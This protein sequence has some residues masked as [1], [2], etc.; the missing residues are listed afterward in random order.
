MKIRKNTEIENAL[1]AR[2]LEK[3]KPSVISTDI[4]MHA[5]EKRVSIR[6]Y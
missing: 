5:Q 2:F 3:N 1:I 4:D 6:G